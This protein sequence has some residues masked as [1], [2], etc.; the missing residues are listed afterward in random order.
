MKI[1]VLIVEDNEQKYNE[2]AEIFN[3]YNANIELSNNVYDSKVKL[4]NKHYDFL[5]LDINLPYEDGEECSPEAGYR[6]FKEISSELPMIKKPSEVIIVTAY[7]ELQEKYDIEANKIL[8]SIIKYS[9]DEQRWREQIENRIKYFIRSKS[10][11]VSQDTETYRIDLAIITAVAVEF[12]QVYRLMHDTHETKINNDPT[13]YTVGKFKEGDNV[14]NV[15]LAKQ[16]QMGMIAAS[17]LTIKLIQNFRPRYLAMAGI[18]AG[19]RGEVNFGDIIVPTEVWDYGSGK[20]QQEDKKM[21]T[22]DTSNYL[23]KP[24]PKYLDL[25]VS[26]KEIMNKNFNSVLS[27]IKHSWPGPK[28]P[29]ELGLITGPIACGSVVVQNEEIIQKFIDPYNRKV[30]GLDMESYGVFYAVENYIDP[31]PRV[32]VCKSVCDFADS[33]KNDSY[34]AYAAYTSASFIKYLVLNE[35]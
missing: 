1:N 13:I 27:T 15:V 2:I 18:A 26:F 31:K 9:Y 35:L 29:T 23:F 34:Q 32:V 12:D 4:A 22:D 10:D 5:L 33:E 24:D 20:I 8:V 7:P 6:L 19:K 28:P 3:K 11:S 17:V 14:V 25:D 21:V 16:H 30:K